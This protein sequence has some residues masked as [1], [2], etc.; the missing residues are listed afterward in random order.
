M[1][2]LLQWLRQRWKKTDL[3]A[4]TEVPPAVTDTPPEEM[5]SSLD[6]LWTYMNE[7]RYEDVLAVVQ[8]I[9]KQETHPEHTLALKLA[10]LAHFKLGNYQTA[11]AMFQEQ[12]PLSQNPDD[13]F[14]L[15]TAAAL[16]R[17]FELSELACRHA[18]ELYQQH[19][20]PE[21]LPVPQMH[22]YYMLALRDVQAYQKAYEQLTVLK[23][24]YCSLRITDSTFLYIRGVPFFSSVLEAG[25]A[26]LENTNPTA[27]RSL[28]HEL[29]NKVD[30]EG[31]AE[32]D[33]FEK[34]IHWNE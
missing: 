7:E 4:K 21:N 12:V 10:G 5:K 14:N 13:W 3:P 16:N 11:E 1:K 33:D 31:R 27:A 30:E 23:N 15:V 8:P 32:L 2:R 18:I 34:T 6:Y 25:K 19:G 20:K 26:I 28:L 17:N 24:I 9:L 29:R 22:F